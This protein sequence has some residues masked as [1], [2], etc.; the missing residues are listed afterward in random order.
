MKLLTS[1][2]VASGLGLFA[3]S[4]LGAQRS[5]LSPRPDPAREHGRRAQCLRT[6]LGAHLRDRPPHDVLQLREPDAGWWKRHM[7]ID[8][9]RR[10]VDSSRDRACPD[11]YRIFRG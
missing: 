4:A 5:P 9:R 10:S 6:G 1:A 2:L 3:F 7:Y 8:A 11:Q